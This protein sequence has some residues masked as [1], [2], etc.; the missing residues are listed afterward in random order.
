MFPWWKHAVV[1]IASLV[2]FVA[3]DITWISLVAGQ[4]YAKV[5]GDILRQPDPLAGILAWTCIVGA[6]YYFALPSSRGS[7]VLALR[8]GALLGLGLYGCYEFT[9]LSILTR[10]TWA[11][12]AVDTLWGCVACGVVCWVQLALTRRLA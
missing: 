3:L 12:A 4:I 9:N 5:L 2:A 1:F 11:L 6:V 8:Q 10:W 7:P